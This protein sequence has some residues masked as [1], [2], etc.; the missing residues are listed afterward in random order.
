METYGA[1]FTSQ[2]HQCSVLFGRFRNLKYTKQ[3]KDPVFIYEYQNCC[4][5]PFSD[6]Y[7][8]VCKMP[9]STEN[10]LACSRR[11]KFDS[12]DKLFQTLSSDPN[13]YQEL[14]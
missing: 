13:D 11:G 2:L 1:F 10:D 8:S 14:I 9:S 7:L 5:H 4:V 12:E 3:I 6:E